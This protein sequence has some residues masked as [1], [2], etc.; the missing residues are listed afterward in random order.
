[1][2]EILRYTRENDVDF[3]YIP[4]NCVYYMSIYTFEIVFIFVYLYLYLSFYIHIWLFMSNY[5]CYFVLFLAIIRPIYW[6]NMSI[7]AYF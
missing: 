4:S 2:R 6:R 1:M 7:H 3:V 5:V